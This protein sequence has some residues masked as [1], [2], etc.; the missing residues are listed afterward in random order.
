M[1]LYG[2]STH[3]TSSRRCVAIKQKVLLNHLISRQKQPFPVL[4]D[5][6]KT[7]IS[8]VHLCDSDKETNA[9]LHLDY[10]MTI[11]KGNK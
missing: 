1:Y 11:P 8:F 5:I 2:V 4:Q 10:S 7:Q 9:D 3:L 6:S